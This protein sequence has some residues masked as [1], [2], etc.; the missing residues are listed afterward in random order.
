MF[1]HDVVQRVQPA[2]G[3][4]GILLA[5]VQDVDQAKLGPIEPM[6][7]LR[8]G[9]L[10]ASPLAP[11][12]QLHD[13][14]VPLLFLRSQPVVDIG[15]DLNAAVGKA[16]AKTDSAGIHPPVAERTA[17]TRRLRPSL[18]DNCRKDDSGQHGHSRCP[19]PYY[20]PEVHDNHSTA[21]SLGRYWSTRH[22][23]TR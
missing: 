2:R 14:Q 22:Q 11:I 6:P 3:I 4:V 1:F 9:L 20:V 12:V 17:P 13:G 16:A 10:A 23:A 21:H 15:S 5:E 7:Q 19:D 8:V 18:A